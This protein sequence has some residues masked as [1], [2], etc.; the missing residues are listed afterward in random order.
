MVR[1]VV[2]AVAGA[3]VLFIWGFVSWVVIPW[4]TIDELPDEHQVIR[5]LGSDTESGVYWY[6]WTTDMALSEDV[7]N[8]QIEKHEAGPVGVIVHHAEGRPVMPL[9]MHVWGIA[10][11]FVTAVSAAIL[12]NMAVT[13]LGG[14][15][16]RV[17]FVTLI[18]VFVAAGATMVNWNYMLYPLDFSLH[19]A[20]DNVVAALLLGL[21]LGAIVKAPSNRMAAVGAGT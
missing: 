18:G 14:Y 1:I 10:L 11:Y 2:A 21:V 17:L 20:A 13:S 3:V 19:L 4:H 15:V 9:S 8:R 7:R 6:P 5:A 12:L 16:S